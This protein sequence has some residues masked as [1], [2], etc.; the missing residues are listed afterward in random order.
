MNASTTIAK[1]AS[2]TEAQPLVVLLTGGLY[3][4]V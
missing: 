2:T 4:K 1:T 3:R